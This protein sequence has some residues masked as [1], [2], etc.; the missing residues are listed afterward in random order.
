MGALLLTITGGEPLVRRDFFEIAR[1]AREKRFAVILFSSGT[2]IREREA[3]RIRDLSPLRVEISVHGAE[4]ETHDSITGVRGS[5]EK[6]WHAV[7]LLKKRGIRVYLKGPL[8]DRNCLQAVRIR[9]QTREEGLEC[10]FD[11]IIVPKN[12]GSPGAVGHRMR[13]E[14]LRDL[15]EN[16]ILFP[17][18]KLRIFPT[19]P[20]GPPCKA[21]HNSL[22]IGPTGDVMPCMQLMTVAGNVRE[23]TVREIWRNSVFNEIRSVKGT[24]IAVCR[25]C[26]IRDFCGRCPGIAQLE[27]GDPLG[28]SRIACIH[29]RI[30]SDLYHR[31]KGAWWRNMGPTFHSGVKPL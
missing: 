2:L 4:A 25:D 16:E 17:P 20:E 11:T 3:D 1:H 21:G 8:M 14:Q 12:D 24:D 22:H 31:R 9:E 7:R 26:H 6:A 30:A 28:P 29:A 10:G 15:M 23:G 5:Y 18:E 13:P 27:D 19:D